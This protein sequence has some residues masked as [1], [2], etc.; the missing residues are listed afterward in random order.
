M[1]RLISW[2]RGLRL[3]NPRFK[4]NNPTIVNKDETKEGK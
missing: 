2:L 3:F 1:K 4:I